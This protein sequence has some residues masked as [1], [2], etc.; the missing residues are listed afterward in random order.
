MYLGKIIVIAI[1]LLLSC[2]S[3]NKKN[4][5]PS[6]KNMQQLYY[7]QEGK[8]YVIKTVSRKY[9]FA[10]SFANFYY[11]LV[12]VNNVNTP[13]DKFTLALTTSKKIIPIKACFTAGS[14]SLG[15]PILDIQSVYYSLIRGNN[16]LVGTYDSYDH[17][18]A[19]TKMTALAERQFYSS[20]N[21]Y[22]YSIK[23]GEAVLCENDFINPSGGCA[24]YFTPSIAMALN[25]FV[26]ANIT[27]TPDTY[28]SNVTFTYF[29][30]Q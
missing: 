26:Q 8:P 18:S 5:N 12:Y 7:T 9:N 13:T 4:I 1:L 23:Y 14:V 20:D 15:T 27:T 19:I 21:F 10:E 6:K 11:A 29:E 30:L 28:S 2:L 25:N 24:F 22:G 3:C 17:L 16:A